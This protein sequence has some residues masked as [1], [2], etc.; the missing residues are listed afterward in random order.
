MRGACSRFG[1]SFWS[2]V[3]GT[4]GKDYQEA[5]RETDLLLNSLDLNSLRDELPPNLPYGSQRQVQLAIALA[6]RPEVILLDEPVSGMNS[7]EAARMATA[8]RGTRESGVTVIVVEHN[9]SFV[10]N[11]CDRIIVLDHGT[12]IAEGLPEEIQKNPKVIEAY[13]GAE[14]AA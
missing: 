1:G 6:T 3:L 4:K 7:T 11:L 9:M 14:N 12:K 2:G 10:M 5:C 13:L 8:V